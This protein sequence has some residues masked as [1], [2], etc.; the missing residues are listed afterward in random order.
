MSIV[1]ETWFVLLNWVF[2]FALQKGSLLLMSV[3]CWILGCICCQPNW[4]EVCKTLVFHNRQGQ[5]AT[6][7]QIRQYG[8]GDGFLL[9]MIRIVLPYSEVEGFCGSLLMLLFF[10]CSSNL[11]GVNIF[12]NI[13]QC[14]KEQRELC[15]INNT[16]I[17]VIHLIINLIAKHNQ[18]AVKIVLTF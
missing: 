2:S 4:Q 16:I 9:W 3:F 10:W 12:K 6:D 18:L 8:V 1:T 17:H 5:V 14:L 7:N 15:L 11:Q 13:K